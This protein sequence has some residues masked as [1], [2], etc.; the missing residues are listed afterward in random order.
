VQLVRER[1]IFQLVN[2]RRG[3]SE[4]REGGEV[5]LPEKGVSIVD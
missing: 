4:Q 5:V 2:P 1:C 3:V